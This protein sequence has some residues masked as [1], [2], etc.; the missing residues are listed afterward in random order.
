M[1]RSFTSKK[2]GGERRPGKRPKRTPVA[3]EA[4]LPSAAA[5]VL[6]TTSTNLAQTASP[7]SDIFA[8]AG[9]YRMLPTHSR[10]SFTVDENA[11][12]M[13]C[14]RYFVEVNLHVGTLQRSYACSEFRHLIWVLSFVRRLAVAIEYV[15]IINVSDHSLLGKANMMMMP[16]LS[17]PGRAILCRISVSPWRSRRT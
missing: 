2:S 11:L 7:A 4:I 13:L 9:D 12:F 8:G 15:F 1:K 5:S 17:S 3:P 6:T 14:D 10:R 16:L